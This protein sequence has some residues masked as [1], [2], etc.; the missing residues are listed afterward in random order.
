MSDDTIYERIFDAI[1]EQR[2]TPNV[3][4]NEED[5][6]EVFDVSRTVIRRILQRLS[7]DGAVTI[8]KNRGAYVAA[9]SAEQVKE[10][11]HARRVVEQGIVAAACR[12]AKKEDLER[13]RGI[14]TAEHES[15][16]NGDR[17]S[18]I[19]LSGEFHLEIARIADNG[20]LYGFLRQLVVR[21]SI[22]RASFEQSGVSP[23]SSHDHD[24]LVK[25]I[26][27]GNVEGAVDLIISHLESS[28][29]ELNV[30][31]AEKSPDLKSIFG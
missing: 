28:E 25:A 2:L 9:L 7:H 16:E 23:C 11:Y 5:L 3:K 14:I 12:S 29:S 26:E 24:G 17:G 1:L 15:I 6:A 19:R 18:R 22:A 13:L 21:T 20:L 4:V 10:L 8:H 27:A 30:E 31:N